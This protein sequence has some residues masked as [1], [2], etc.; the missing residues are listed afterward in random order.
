MKIDTDDHTTGASAGYDG[1][2]GWHSC[3]RCGR[4]RWRDPSDPPPD[5]DCITHLREVIDAIL[6]ALR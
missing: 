5:H 6:E 1:T 2:A 3:E 4:T